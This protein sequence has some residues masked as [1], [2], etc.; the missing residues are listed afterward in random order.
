[1]PT[2]D[3]KSVQHTI[4]IITEIINNRINVE[5]NV[6]SYG[7]FDTDW[8]YTVVL[9]SLSSLLCE[10]RQK[11]FSFSCIYLE[12]FF[13]VPL[14][15]MPDT[16]NM[17]TCTKNE[18]TTETSPV[19]IQYGVLQQYVL[20]WPWRTDYNLWEWNS[21]CYI[22][23]RLFKFIFFHLMGFYSWHWILHNIHY[24]EKKNIFNIVKKHASFCLK[25]M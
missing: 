2:S 19:N 15:R 6:W 18:D 8:F 7:L 5:K 22:I 3:V 1:M 14:Y 16:I 11:L 13:Y 21:W 25:R 17:N 12:M 23:F 24:L 4:A 20:P 9:V 10:T